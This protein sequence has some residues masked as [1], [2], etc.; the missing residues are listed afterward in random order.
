MATKV[1]KE[2]FPRFYAQVS[3]DEPIVREHVDQLAKYNIITAGSR[4]DE[5]S[6]AAIKKIK[7]LNPEAIVLRYLNLTDLDQGS[8][9]LYDIQINHPDWLLRDKKG[10]PCRAYNL[11]KGRGLHSGTRWAMDPHSD[12]RKF[13]ARRAS[14]I[15]EL[16]YDGIFADNAWKFY[17]WEDNYWELD[18]T[19]DEW[20]Q[21]W[22]EFFGH[23]KARLGDKLF[24]C[25]GEPRSIWRTPTGPCWRALCVLTSE[26]LR[27]SW[28]RLS[29]LVRQAKSRLPIVTIATR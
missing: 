11:D 18:M 15:M 19:N 1:L 21:A 24:I 3:L 23:V 13:Y 29:W 16:G 12:W 10:N 25:N 5:I 14:E 27:R 17:N 2:S 28:R 22:A 4:D 7:S 6:R 8:P 26:I 9:E 20:I